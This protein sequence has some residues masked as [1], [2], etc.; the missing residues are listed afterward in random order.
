VCARPR[1][2]PS[3]GLSG[4]LSDRPERYL[5]EQLGDLGAKAVGKVRL[6]TPFVEIIRYAR[7]AESKLIVMSAHTVTAGS[8]TCCWAAPPKQFCAKR[9]APCSRSAA[10]T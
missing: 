4:L 5:A 10:P 2:I 9:I 8:S 3:R 1:L 6:G 7:E